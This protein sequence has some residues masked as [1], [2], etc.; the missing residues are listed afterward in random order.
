VGSWPGPGRMQMAVIPGWTLLMV[1][2]CLPPPA[3]TAAARCPL[4]RSS[5]CAPPEE[6]WHGALPLY[7][8]Q[9]HLPLV[10]VGCA[11]E[12]HFVRNTDESNRGPFDAHTCI[13]HPA[14][15]SGGGPAAR[16][17]SERRASSSVPW[18]H[19]AAV[20][21]VNCSEHVSELL[22]CTA[23][24]FANQCR[25]N[26]KPSCSRAS[27]RC[28]FCPFCRLTRI[29]SSRRSDASSP[30]L[31]ASGPANTCL[32]LKSAGRA[33]RASYSAPLTSHQQTISTPVLLLSKCAKP[34]TEVSN[35]P[36][37]ACGSAGWRA[38]PSRLSL[39]LAGGGCQPVGT[40]RRANH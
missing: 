12:W 20:D 15:R 34:R 37:S 16:E 9:C 29:S 4:P 23:P 35:T 24:K 11:G 36:R 40:A 31:T 25:V 19:T 38:V 18:C 7:H 33:V 21:S 27:C 8:C 3:A 30:S 14:T 39:S 5:S 10:A 13:M 17:V 28:F 22:S 26:E 1:V 2:C 32:E 6:D